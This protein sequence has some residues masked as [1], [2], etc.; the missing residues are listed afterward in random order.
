MVLCFLRTR[1]LQAEGRPPV[2][3]HCCRCSCAALLTGH[4][5]LAEGMPSITNRLT[6]EQRASLCYSGKRTRVN[7]TSQHKGAKINPGNKGASS[8]GV[9]ESWWCCKFI[10]CEAS[11]HTSAFPQQQRFLPRVKWHEQP[12]KRVQCRMNKDPKR[13]PPWYYG[14]VYML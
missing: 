6:E 9:T 8:V 3:N 2:I 4:A 13:T 1:T 14:L 7:C 11:A 5:G 10:H 12:G